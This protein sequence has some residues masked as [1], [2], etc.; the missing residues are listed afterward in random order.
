MLRLSIPLLPRHI[1]PQPKSERKVSTPAAAMSTGCQPCQPCQPNFFG[2]AATGL[3]RPELPA[4]VLYR[5]RD[6]NLS[7]RVRFTPDIVA[8]VE[9]RTTLKISRKLIFV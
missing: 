2:C 6:P 5:Q 3:A 7:L 4:V 9:N 1:V 8:K